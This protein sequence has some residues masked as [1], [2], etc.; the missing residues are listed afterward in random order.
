MPARVG[1][2]LVRV[3]TVLEA[4]GEHGDHYL[5]RVYTANEVEDCRR[6]GDVDP[7]RLAARFA[8][9]EATAKALRVGPA[10]PLPLTAIEVVRDPAGFPELALH[11]PAAA[12]AAANRVTAL[13]LSLTHEEDYAAAVVLAEIRPPGP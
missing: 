10:D 7:L 9:K 11:G 12:L 1:I 3:S 5:R 13:A 4:L 6:G 2:D 8:A